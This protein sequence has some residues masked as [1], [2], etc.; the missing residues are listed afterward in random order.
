MA[1]IVLDQPLSQPDDQPEPPP[2]QVVEYRRRRHLPVHPLVV[3]LAVQAGL[4][5]ALVRSNT[6]F[7]DEALYL[8]AG[9]LEWAH[10]L[11]GSPIPAFPTYFSGAPVIYPPLGALADSVGGL[12]GARL[13]S[14][15]FMLGATALLYA[16][17][18][19]LFGRR[20]AACAAAVF[21]V[22]GPTQNLGAFATYDAMAI[23]LIALAT[24]CAVR[25]QGAVTAG[26]SELFLVGTGLAL[27][28]ADA[29]KYASALWTPVVL[30]VVCLTAPTDGW[31]RPMLR[32]CRVAVYVGAPLAIVLFRFGGNSYIHGILFTTL[33]RRAEGLSASV[34][35]ILFDSFAWV[36]IV[37]GLAL[38]GTVVSYFTSSRRTTALC[39]VLTV[40]V[41]LAPLHQAQIHTLISLHKHVIFGA[42]F[43]AIVA[44]YLL[45]T[46]GKV[47]PD[48]GWR[49]GAVA[50]G[51]ALFIGIPQ[52]QAS[53][54]FAWPNVTKMNAEL[55]RVIPKVGCPCLVAQQNPLRYYLP[56][57]SA[58]EKITG[59]YSF[60]YWDNAQH[61]LLN[62][63]PA[64]DRA[65]KHHYFS[66]VEID[67]AENAALYTSVIR[68]LH[69]TPGYR[70]ADSI[71]IDHWGRKTMQIWWFAGTGSH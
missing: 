24:W 67:P 62:G 71:P 39:A 10:W 58:A 18:L 23:F 38:A 56:E 32:G 4:S 16:T 6:A 66:V 20:A 63:L 55:A 70:L 65:I 69:T 43:G 64:Y 3:V 9:H 12:A 42:W 68:S 60:Y 7:S 21:V 5:L 11:H 25:S 8:W 29:T 2:L 33:E 34:P 19:R 40:A 26:A 53:A 44:G 51:I 35:S 52:A 28:L 45:D 46:A 13:L 48:R 14:L 50:A 57:L 15:C 47:N 27:A 61:K 31:L 49:V 17:T 59:P 54:L 41:L 30:A 22:L 36:G 1:T 37:L